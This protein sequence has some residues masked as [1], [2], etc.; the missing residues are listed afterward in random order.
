MYIKIYTIIPFEFLYS[1]FCIN[2]AKR[3]SSANLKEL[4]GNGY[5]KRQKISIA[6]TLYL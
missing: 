5:N 3:R 4:E 1:K 6:T 2:S